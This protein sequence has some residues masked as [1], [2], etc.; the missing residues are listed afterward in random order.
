MAEIDPKHA[1]KK[2][3]LKTAGV[4]MMVIG[5]VC[6][7]IGLI[8]FFSAFSGNG[9]PTLFW[10]LFIGFPLL[11]IG[12]KV[13][14]FAFLGEVSRYAAGEVAPVAKDALDYLSE[15]RSGERTAADLVACPSCSTKNRPDARFCDNCGK[16]LA[17]ACPSC[18][19]VNDDD[20]RFCDG[21]GTALA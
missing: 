6:S 3:T 5:G 14:G 19:R 11:G 17:K 2:D 20:S 10:L 18:G 13:A 7:L 9:E 12:T 21:C 1:Q 16:A 8:D 15:G 4:L